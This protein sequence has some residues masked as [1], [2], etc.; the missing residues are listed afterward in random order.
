M[1]QKGVNGL[2]ISGPSVAYHGWGAACLDQCGRYF[3]PFGL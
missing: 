2:K 3:V 1:F